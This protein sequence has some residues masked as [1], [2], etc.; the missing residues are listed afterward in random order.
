MAALPTQA[1][2][3]TRGLV[4]NVGVRPGGRRP[5]CAYRPAE[6][7][8]QGPAPVVLCQLLGSVGVT[9]FAAPDGKAFRCSVGRSCV[10]C[11]FKLAPGCLFPMPSA[12]AFVGAHF[13]LLT[14]QTSSLC[15]A[16]A[17]R[18]RGALPWH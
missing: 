5:V 1:W 15:A 14:E 3:R 18:H 8:L 12:F 17:A 10:P 2:P 13:A 6:A 7:A 9:N 11:L 4:A 16:V